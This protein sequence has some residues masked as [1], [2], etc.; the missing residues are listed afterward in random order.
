M[1]ENFLKD[2]QNLNSKANWANLIVGILLLLI[3]AVGSMWYFGRKP[4]SEVGKV[5]EESVTKEDQVE[6]TDDVKEEASEPE[7]V[8]GT[9]GQI[10]V[11]PNTSSK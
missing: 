2:L 7:N 5:E 6:S 11:L 8:L 4:V 3:L 10:N 1:L 9:G